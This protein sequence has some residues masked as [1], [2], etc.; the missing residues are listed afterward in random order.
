MTRCPEVVPPAEDSRMRAEVEGSPAQCTISSHLWDSVGVIL[1]I[2]LELGSSD[3][4]N[5]S[6]GWKK[7]CHATFIKRLNRTRSSGACCAC[8]SPVLDGITLSLGR[9]TPPV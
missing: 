2:G 8:S 4:C 9:T 6:P 5:A 3:R 7:Q 1:D